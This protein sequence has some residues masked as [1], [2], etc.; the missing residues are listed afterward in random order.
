MRWPVGTAPA[1]F[2]TLIPMS[3]RSLLSI[4]LKEPVHTSASNQHLFNGKI[5]CCARR[6]LSLK[7][8][9][10]ARLKVP[11]T[12]LPHGRTPPRRI[13]SGD[14]IRSGYEFASAWNFF[15]D[16]CTRLPERIRRSLT[17]F[18]GSTIDVH[19]AIGVEGDHK[20]DFAR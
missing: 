12:E 15:M 4:I 13:C 19:A 10:S 11:R 8:G 18:E 6:G 17:S 7:A 16:N 5:L 14:S 20:F 2:I 3:F 1:Y 9:T